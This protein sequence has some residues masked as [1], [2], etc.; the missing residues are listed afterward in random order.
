MAEIP[1]ILFVDDDI[2]FCDLMRSQI[3]AARFNADF[4]H[5]ADTAM[6]R[7]AAKTYD[8][9]ILDIIMPGTNGLELGRIL[10]Q[11]YPSTPLFFLTAQN[12]IQYKAE[13]FE[14]G[15]DDYISKP[16][17]FTELM[18]RIRAVLRRTSPGELAARFSI[19]QYE[20]DSGMRKL[21][22]VNEVKTLSMKEA[23]LLAI[24][25]SNIDR[26]VSRDIFLH[27]V[28]GKTDEF[29][30]D[31]M[32][33]YLTRLRKHLKHDPAVKIENIRGKGFKLMVS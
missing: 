23:E 3:D 18:Y 32:D 33:V 2:S 20:F 7:M 24:L 10:R 17:N 5:D 28:W 30:V 11:D 6:A 21:Y 31:S 26:V 25:C 27:K 8:L 29:T 14:L 22:H 12:E 4:A 9:V 19:G 15:A 16:F 1:R 13:G